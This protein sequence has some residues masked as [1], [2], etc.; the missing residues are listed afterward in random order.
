MAK[1]MVVDDSETVREQLKGILEE[2]GHSVLEAENGEVGLAKIKG[3]A[4]LDLV[5][6]DVNMPVMDGITMCTKLRE[7]LPDHKLPI[8]MLTTES[9]PEL[10]AQ[11]KAAGVMA[12][13]IKPIKKEKILMAIDM[14][15]KK[16]AEN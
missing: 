9:S 8:F 12:W 3:E 7:D 15:L 10:K 1:I 16:M 11:G 13:T 2:G 6:C 4:G 14:I 5:I